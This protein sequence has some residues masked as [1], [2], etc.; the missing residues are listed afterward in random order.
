MDIVIKEFLFV[1][2]IVLV[3]GLIDWI[4]YQVD[5]SKHEKPSISNQE[6]R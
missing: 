6:K 5:K 2:V 3:H 1:L 4:K